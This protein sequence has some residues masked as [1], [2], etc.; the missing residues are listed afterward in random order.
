MNNRLI[1]LGDSAQN[2]WNLWWMR[3]ALSHGNL[4]PF[5]TNVL[6]YPEGVSLAYDTLAPFNG[7]LGIPLQT[8]L[9]M[10]L[11]TTFNTIALLSFVGTGLSTYLLVRSLTGSPTAAFAAG[12]VFTFCPFRMS[13]VSFGN[14]DV[15]STQ[16]VPL[17]AWCLVKLSQ[18]GAFRPQ[19]EMHPSQTQR[20]RYGVGA[21]AALALTGWCSL[22]LAFG[23]GLLAGLLCLFDLCSARQRQVGWKQW[24]VFGLLTCVFM[25]PLILPMIHHAPDFQ[26]EANQ[27]LSSTQNSADLLGFFVP[28]SLTNPLVKRSLPPA[29]SHQIEQIYGMFFGNSA[30]K[31]VFVGYSVL[32]IV[33]ISVWVARSEA[34]RRWLAIALTAF[35][36][37]LGPVLYVAGKP[38]LSPLPYTLFLHLPLLRAGRTPSRLA[39]IL[40]LALAVIAGYGLAAMERRWRRAYWGTLLA[41]ALIF[42]EFLIIPLPLDKRVA[43]APAYYHQLAQESQGAV[44]DVPIDLYGAQGPA[45]DYLLYQTIHQKPIVGGYISRTPRHVLELFE[46]PFLNQLRARI[47]ND[48]E[49]YAFPPDLIQLGLGELRSINVQYIILHKQMLSAS[50]S[51]IVRTALTTLL[52]DPDY[53]DEAI[54]VWQLDTSTSQ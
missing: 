52:H 6:Y 34:V 38:T 51:H 47:Y 19:I 31:T 17:T 37:C 12:V 39:F 21:A 22:E 42:L 26:A 16:F 32:I 54:L 44:L 46:H 53:E 2:V 4:A 48:T 50:D 23:T 3:W 1:G 14:L 11:P 20:W 5:Y 49:P 36:L 8:V 15:Y 13:R 35:V 27:Y 28:D 43:S 24:L 45:A 18:T 40:M 25:S 10:G 33:L 29:M 7:L 9:G 30:E 41:S